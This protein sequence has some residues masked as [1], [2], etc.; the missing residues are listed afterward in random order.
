MKVLVLNTGS[1][2]LKYSLFESDGERLL[3]DGLADWSRA[4]ARL[5]ARRPGRPEASRELSLRRH[6]DAVGPALDELI[7]EGQRLIDALDA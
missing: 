4:P 3:G 2:S 7:C 6:G 5:T 1:S